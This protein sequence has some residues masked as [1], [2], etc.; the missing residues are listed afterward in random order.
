MPAR[1]DRAHRGRTQERSLLV[2]LSL[3][4]AGAC[5]EEAPTTVRNLS[6]DLNTDL[7]VSR[8]APD[9]IPA[10]SEPEMV[11]PDHPDA[12]YL[13]DSDRVLGV[14]MNGEARAYP[15][16]ILWYHE[17]VNDRIG[18]DWVSVTFC[19]LTGSGLA[20]D[21]EL[22]PRRLELGVSGLLF[23]N[24]LVLFDRTTE[25]VY[26]PQL[27]V[28]GA[29]EGFRGSS[30]KL[31]P[32][33]EMS[34]GRWKQLHPGTKVVTGRQRFGFSYRSYPYDTYNE[35]TDNGLL[36]PMSVD[37]SRLIKERVLAIRDG[38]GGRGYPYGEL[39]SLGPVAVVNETVGGVPTAVFFDQSAGQTA[40]AFDA[41]LNGET[42]TFDAS[43]TGAWT[44]RETGSTWAIDGSAIDGPLAGGRLQTRAD[45]YT[46]FWF[47]WRHFQPQG[48]MFSAP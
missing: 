46:V 2:V 6:C 21:P 45:A 44:D 16:N 47:A 33:Q 14:Y 48:R 37:R 3:V 31:L 42:L 34:W 22:G 40:L 10:L 12:G 13:L 28:T 27:N 30:L 7:L 23:A 17:I 43:P 25:E 29:C 8:V 38:A 11:S 32:L 19:P 1:S 39:A 26:G 24:N 5:G 9:A 18:S 15:H 36:V 35:I 41:R 20:F 4:T